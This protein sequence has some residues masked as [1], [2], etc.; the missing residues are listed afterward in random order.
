MKN[1]TLYARFQ[2]INEQGDYRDKYKPIANKKEARNAVETM[3]LELAQHGEETLRSDKIAF[4]EVADK[5]EEIELVPAV[6]QN[7]VKIQGRRS[8]ASLKSAIKALRAHFGNKLLRSIKPS[9]VKAYKS[10]RL[11][12]PVE[13]EVKVK[14]K[15]IDTATGKEKTVIHKVIRR[16]ER[17]ISGVNRELAWLRAILNF[18]IENEWLITNPFAKSKGVISTAG[19][20]ERDRIL[21]FTE[22]ERLLSHCTDQRAHIRPM[23]VCAVDTAMR[24]GEILKLRWRDV[25]LETQEIY[26]PREISKTGYDRTVGITARLKRELEKLWEMSPKRPDLLVFGIKA[27]F[28]KAF[29]TARDMAKLENL[30]F[31]DCRHTA[32]TRMIASGSPHVE[33]MKI[34]GHKQL[35]TFLRY[36]NIKQETTQKCAS[37]LDEYLSQSQH[38]QKIETDFVS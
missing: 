32:T 6:Y 25:K 3:R 36:L 13:V 23:V 1:G 9:D 19:E 26:V 38:S 14:S 34:T 21:S 7:G 37:R 29:E 5:Y 15:V 4:G 35:K 16:S 33:V 17:K 20:V 12:T 2:Y 11:N 10:K 27:D 8:I 30:H 24:K 18:A 22:E 31:H 28:S